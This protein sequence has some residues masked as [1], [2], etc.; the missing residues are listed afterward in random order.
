MKAEKGMASSSE[1]DGSNGSADGGGQGSI[2]DLL[3]CIFEVER[4]DRV[5]KPARADIQNAVWVHPASA[6]SEHSADV[7][8]AD[9]E[10]SD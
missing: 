3:R 4:R 8:K 5:H 2:R 9:D 1:N 7:R 10:D 6:A